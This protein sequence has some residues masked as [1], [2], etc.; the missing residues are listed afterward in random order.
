M[1]TIQ[2]FLEKYAIE[3]PSLVA[4]IAADVVDHVMYVFAESNGGSNR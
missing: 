4:R 3:E 2:R 1:T